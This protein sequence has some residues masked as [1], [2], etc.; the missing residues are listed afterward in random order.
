MWNDVDLRKLFLAQ[1]PLVDVRAPIEF[2][3]GKIPFSINLPILNNE[4]RVQ[5][6]TTYKNQGQAAA[7]LLGQQLVSGINKDERVNQWIKFIQ[8]NPEAQVFCFRGGMRSKISCEWITE[9]GFPRTP[10]VGGYKRMRNFFLSL[11]NEGPLPKI[12]RLGGL[13]GCGKTELLL[14]LKKHIDLEGLANHRG[15]AFGF[16]GQQPTQITFENQLAFKILQLPERVMLEDESSAIGNVV[17]PVRFFEEM[18]RAPL[19]MLELPLE[20]RIVNIFN[21]Y[22]LRNDSIFFTNALQAISKRLGG[23]KTNDLLN[24]VKIAYEYGM[25][26]R[27]HREWISIL[28]C[29]YYDKFYQK[30]LEKQKNLILFRGSREEILQW[31]VDFQ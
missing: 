22:V 2:E 3:A 4:E 13:T 7:V 8:Q 31:A 1:T 30:S 9:N 24:K 18:K 23:L 16:M 25:N 29:D 20:D 26:L 17:I 11:L 28:L 15:S 5:V 14:K 21:S 19:V 12:F 27:E 10:I 6:G